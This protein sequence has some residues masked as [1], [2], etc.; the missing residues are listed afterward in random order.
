[1]IQPG[2]GLQPLPL[3]PLPLGAI[4]PGGW[5]AHQLRIQADGLSGHL[6][7]FWPSISE[8][9]WIGGQAEGWERGPYWLDGLVPLAYLL[10]DET[11]KSKVRFWLDYILDHQ[12]A[13]GWLGP[14]VDKEHG[15]EYDPWPRFPLLKAFTQ[16]YEATGDARIIPAMQRFLKKLDEILDE[17]VLKLWGY[18]RWA[19]LAV[20]IFW[21][22]DRT[23]EE[24]LLELGRKVHRQGFD[25]GQYFKTF[26]DLDKVSADNCTLINHGVNNAMGLKNPAVWSRLSGQPEDLLDTFRIIATLDRYHG[27]ANGV[28]SCDEHLAGLSPS[29]GTELCT[30]VEYMY[31]LEQAIAISQVPALAERLELIAYNALPATFTPDMWAHQY[32]QQVNQAICRVSEDRVYT[33]NFADSNIYGLEPNFGCCTAN[34]HQ[35][36]P[37]FVSHMWMQAEDGGLTAVAYGPCTVAV[38]VDNVAV[39]LEVETAYPFEGEV[40]IRVKTAR[41]IEFPL[42]LRIPVWAP[43]STVRVGQDKVIEVENGT[44]FSL[45]GEWSGE[46]VL[47]LKFPLEARVERRYNGS[48]AIYRG[49]LLYGLKISEDFRQLRGQIPHADW[50]VYPNSPWNYGLELDPDRPGAALSFETDTVGIQPFAPASAPVRAK[51]KGRRIPGWQLEHNAAGPVP[52]SP[53]SAGPLEELVLLPYGCTNLRIA[54]FPLLMPGKKSNT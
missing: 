50:E 49:P 53:E 22:Y 34:L 4:K 21:L 7:E 38:Q 20:S 47:T 1:M 33:N 27:Q 43:G 9:A 52:V 28:F 5:L 39:Q 12:H 18:F 46:T 35:G 25:W 16:F 2:T 51:V 6:D 44:V 54:E 37:K 31:S 15:Y 3:Q 48:V 8:S 13:D 45:S 19:D 36:W 14:L 10:D 41:P 11:L 30:V 32:D 17:Q 42:N 29:Q 23:N 24:W 26:P 40:K